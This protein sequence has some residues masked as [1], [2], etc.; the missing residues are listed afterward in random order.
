[1][2]EVLA[3]ERVVRQRGPVVTFSGVD[4]SGKTTL[5][6]AAA[7]E[8]RRQGY[9]VRILRVY[10][11]SVMAVAGWML[12]NILPGRAPAQKEQ[13]QGRRSGAISALWKR[14]VFQADYFMLWALVRFLSGR[15]FAVVCDRYA[16]DSLVTLLHD[17][18]CSEEFFERF[19]TMA[20]PPD[21]AF[22][23][24]ADEKVIF[25]RRSKADSKPAQSLNEYYLK[26]TDFGDFWIV[27]T[28]DGRQA[29]SEIRGILSYTGRRW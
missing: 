2:S 5:A 28:S 16:Y 12:A 8:L 11:I 19:V 29:R 27:D 6:L 20:P 22:Y 24:R 13:A 15:G 10:P 25:G 26:L 4:G 18:A 3:Q 21:A 1:M 23:L 9:R 14:L 17:G 7:D